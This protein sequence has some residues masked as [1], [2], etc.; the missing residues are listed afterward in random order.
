LPQ[1]RLDFDWRLEMRQG[2]VADDDDVDTCRPDRQGAE[3][4]YGASEPKVTGGCFASCSIDGAVRDI[5]ARHPEP[6]REE[7]KR[8]RANA[9]RGVEYRER[10]R[11]PMLTNERR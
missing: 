8:L 4:G 6:E 11:P 9:D 10:A 1:R 3:V 7:S 5:G 2:V